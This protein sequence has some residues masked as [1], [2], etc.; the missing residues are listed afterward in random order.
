MTK[1][2]WIYTHNF[3]Q[4]GAPLVMAS[5]ARQLAA[6]GWRDRLRVVS[7]GG[8]HD[9]R[10]STLQSELSAEGIHCSVLDHDQ[11][12]PKPHSGDQLLLNSLVL[13][14]HV[15][16]QALDWTSQNR[17]SR[18]DW[19]AHEGGPAVC[20]PGSSWSERLR[21][22]L[23]AGHLQLRV[24][25]VHT[26]TTYQRWLNYS[27]DALA[28]LWPELD[29][30]QQLWGSSASDFQELRLQLTAA[31]GSGHKGHV[32]L[33]QLLAAALEE[34]PQNTVGMR[35]IRLRFIG[36]EQG[37]YA[38]LARHV[39]QQGEQLLGDSFAWVPAQDRHLALQAMAE[40][41]IAVSCSLSET[42][43]LVMAE[44]MA[45]G[46][47]LLRT[48]TGGWQEQLMD[49]EGGF[50]LGE[51]SSSPQSEQVAVLQQLRDPQCVPEA[52]LQRMRAK[53]QQ[54]AGRF[55]CVNFGAWLCS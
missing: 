54:H 42:F 47:P 14:E 4:S 25:S 52:V 37:P 26:L 22:A 16:Q 8:L 53:G 24:P 55:C 6:L 17:L 2:F 50:D 49:A 1:H 11:S 35:P 38:A 10:H 5:I 29:V 51:V 12:P 19:Y 41:N 13:P 36:V 28:V 23:Q 9:R 3:T 44:A 48:R 21:S 20:L 31:V 15:I 46:Q 27:E 18:L 40:S 43:S 30:P 7:W 39:C 34:C 32:W 45:L 33:L